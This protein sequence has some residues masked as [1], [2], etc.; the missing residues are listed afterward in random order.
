M[1]PVAIFDGGRMFM[2]TIWSISGSEK[3]AQIIFKVVTY[4]ILAALLVL[5][6]GWFIAIF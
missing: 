4:I 5:M 3:F 1:W 2:L 6:F